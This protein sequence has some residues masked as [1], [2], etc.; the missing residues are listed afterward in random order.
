MLRQDFVIRNDLPCGSTIGP[1]VSAK[2]GI[3]TIDVG[4]PQLSMHSIREMCCTS[5]VHQATSL[6]QVLRPGRTLHSELLNNFFNPLKC[7]G[8]R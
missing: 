2:L 4:C 5:S 8:V 3:A 7:S 1:I 6:F